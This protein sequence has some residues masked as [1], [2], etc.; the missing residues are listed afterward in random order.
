MFACNGIQ[1]NHE[2]PRH[3]ETFVRKKI[4]RYVLEHRKMQ[5]E[6]YAKWFDIGLVR[7]FAFKAKKENWSGIKG[8]CRGLMRKWGAAPHLLGLGIAVPASI[9]R[10]RPRCYRH[11]Y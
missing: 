3:G 8:V 1:F 5:E 10:Q 11:R 4:T 7:H 2:S 6:R 9:A